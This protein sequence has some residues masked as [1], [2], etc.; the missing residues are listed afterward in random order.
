M[1]HY[2]EIEFTDLIKKMWNSHLFHVVI[3]ILQH[4]FLEQEQKQEATK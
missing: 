3:T 4:A 2:L 1:I